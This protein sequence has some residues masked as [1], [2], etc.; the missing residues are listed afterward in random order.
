MSKLKERKHSQKPCIFEGGETYQKKPYIFEGG[1]HP[2][3]MRHF[4]KCLM[5]WCAHAEAFC[6]MPHDVVRTC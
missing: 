4:A 1:M 5:M 3:A 2:A 6:K